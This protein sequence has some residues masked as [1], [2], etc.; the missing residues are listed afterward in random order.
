MEGEGYPLSQK[1]IQHE[2]MMEMVPMIITCNSEPDWNRA[3]S[4]NRD[5]MKNAFETRVVRLTLEQVHPK[6][7]YYPYIPEHAAFVFKCMIRDYRKQLRSS[8]RLVKEINV[9]K[10]P[11]EIIKSNNLLEEF[12]NEEFE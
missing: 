4:H 6:G 5:E 7:T 11:E 1:Y 2:V 8:Q 10:S 9:I 3:P 12:P